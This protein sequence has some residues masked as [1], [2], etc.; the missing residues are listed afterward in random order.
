MLTCEV[1]E[2][3][4]GLLFVEAIRTDHLKEEDADAPLFS[5]EAFLGILQV[6]KT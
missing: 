4:N 6:L 5:F 3:T 1:D 2:I